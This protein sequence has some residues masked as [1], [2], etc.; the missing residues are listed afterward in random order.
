MLPQRRNPVIL[1]PLSPSFILSFRFFFFWLLINVLFD[2]LEVVAA[3]FGA[4]QSIATS[5]SS[6]RTHPS[7]RFRFICYHFTLRMTFPCPW[8]LLMDASIVWSWTAGVGHWS[9][10]PCLSITAS[11]PGQKPR[12]CCSWLRSSSEKKWAADAAR[13]PLTQRSRSRVRMAMCL[14]STFLPSCYAMQTA[15]S[16]LHWGRFLPLCVWH[17]AYVNW[18]DI[19]WVC[20][21]RYK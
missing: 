10:L 4:L 14:A 19:K 6:S 8:L 20:L 7:L 15:R 18:W 11:L 21:C 5:I 9:G 12:Q 1:S 17:A 2:G 13:H 3:F 16:V